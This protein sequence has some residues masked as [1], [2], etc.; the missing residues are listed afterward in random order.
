MQSVGLVFVQTLFGAAAQIL[1]KT[2]TTSVE[3]GGIMAFAAALFT[4]LHLFGGYALYGLSTVLLTLALRDGELSRLYPIIS[5]TF[6][7]VTI[8][9]SIIFREAIT[10]HKLIAVSVI[11]A[12]VAVLGAASQKK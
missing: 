2:G 4:N 7:W 12:G 9:S 11:V 5:L 3:G 10:P 8:L 1:M 6:V